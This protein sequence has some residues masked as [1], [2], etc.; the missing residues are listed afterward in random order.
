MIVRI[1]LNHLVGPFTETLIFHGCEEPFKSGLCGTFQ[2]C[3]YDSRTVIKRFSKMSIFETSLPT[4]HIS[5]G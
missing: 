5:P 4:L 3:L 1:Y 2:F